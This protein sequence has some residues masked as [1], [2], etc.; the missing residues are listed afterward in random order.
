MADFDKAFEFIMAQQGHNPYRIEENDAEIV[1]CSNCFKNEGLKLSAVQSG[2]EV[3]GPCKNCGSESGR[4]L[5]RTVVRQI[6]YQFFVIGTIKRFE[7]GGCPMIQFNEQRYGDSDIEVSNFLRDDVVLIEETCKIGFFNYAPRFWMFGEVEPLKALQTEEAQDAVIEKILSSYPVWRLD[8][9][10]AFY[11]L[12]NNPERPHNPHDYDSA[13][14]AFLGLNRFDDKDLP[15]LYAS[16]DLEVCLHE[17]RVTVEDQIYSAKLIPRKPLLVLDLSA[18][19]KEEGSEFDSLDMA[20][21]FL[22]LAGKHSYNICRKIARKVH[23]KGLDGILY[24]SY[25]SLVR[26]GAIPFETIMGMSVRKIEDLRA[27]VQSQSIP[28]LA[29]FGRPISEGNLQVECINK[30][31]IN[32]VSYD[33]SFGPE[34]QVLSVKPENV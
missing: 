7:Y 6:A 20:I 25:F 8:Q 21:H 31:I 26:T 34:T 30:V 28:N 4:K 13:P 29:L 27:Y 15:V 11:R 12:R 3:D 5:S 14:D 9:Q 17:C 16:A 2:E 19:L 23:E 10:H 1:L 18:W 22:F 32:R 24:P 33:L